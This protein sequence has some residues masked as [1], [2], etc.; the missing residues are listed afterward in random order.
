MR[1]M[2]LTGLT[3]GYVECDGRCAYGAGRSLRGVKAHQRDTG[4]C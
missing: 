1:K 3:V 2:H 4:A